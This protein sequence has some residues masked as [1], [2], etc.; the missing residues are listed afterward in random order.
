MIGHLILNHPEV[1]FNLYGCQVNCLPPEINQT[2][3]SCFD[4]LFD[5][6]ISVV[7]LGH[8]S[9]LF[10]DDVLESGDFVGVA[11]FEE[12]VA[13]EL[14]YPLEIPLLLEFIYFAVEHDIFPIIECLLTYS[15]PCAAS[16]THS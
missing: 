12:I 11:E 16:R 13:V 3:L 4:C 10:V 14:G 2:C 15:C 9:L 7:V 1:F 5:D 6:S 8:I